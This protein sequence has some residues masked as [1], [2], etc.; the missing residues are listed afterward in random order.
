M[1]HLGADGAAEQHAAHMLD[2]TI[3]GR[4]VIQLARIGPRMG[5]EF[6]EI[7]RRHRG[8]HN[9]RM[10]RH[11]RHAHQRE[12]LDGIP[13]Q[14][15]H[16]GRIAGVIAIILQQDR[17]PIRRGA[18]HGI[19]RQIAIGPRTVFHH[20]RLAE[21]LAHRF[22]KQAR[23]EIRPPARRIGHHHGDR[24]VR[25]GRL[26]LQAG[27]CGEQAAGGK[28]GATRKAHGVSSSKN[29]ALRLSSTMT[30]RWH[31]APRAKAD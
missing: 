3:A 2:R 21:P 5:D 1:H 20:H 16:H 22:L 8:R 25:E 4:C 15:L 9:D 24:A 31:L 29:R 19:D 12:V 17:M 23:G 11:G 30:A 26:R 13:S 27:W 14:V 10:R 28:Q 6:L 18:R 7:I